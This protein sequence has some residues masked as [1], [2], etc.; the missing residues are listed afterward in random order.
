M[1][2]SEQGEILHFPELPQDGPKL[3]T[4]QSMLRTVELLIIGRD[5]ENTLQS[6]KG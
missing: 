2:R 6:L 4:R 3:L 5:G 1:K